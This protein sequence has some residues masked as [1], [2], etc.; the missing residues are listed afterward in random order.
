MRE[1]N[2]EAATRDNTR[3]PHLWILLKC[4]RVNQYPLRTSQVTMESRTSY[5]TLLVLD[6]NSLTHLRELGIPVKKKEK[7]GKG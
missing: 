7:T 6:H 3:K 2:P 5:G 4:E 1:Y